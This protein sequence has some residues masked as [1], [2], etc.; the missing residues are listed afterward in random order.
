[1]CTIKKE[2]RVRGGGGNQGGAICNMPCIPSP[3]TNNQQL[4]RHP[5][6]ALKKAKAQGAA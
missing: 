1:M 5:T 3:I 4:N 2:S 6:P